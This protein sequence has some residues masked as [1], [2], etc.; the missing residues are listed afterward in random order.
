VLLVVLLR[1]K[2]HS[3][4]ARIG[5]D[6]KSLLDGSLMGTNQERE[7]GGRWW[8]LVEV[9]VEVWP[10][11]RAGVRAVIE[12]VKA[13]WLL[14]ASAV[15]VVWEL[16][17]GT[18][19]QPC[20]QAEGAAMVGPLDFVREQ[21]ERAPARQHLCWQLEGVERAAASWGARRASRMLRAARRARMS[22]NNMLS[23]PEINS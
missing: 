12:S 5:C 13:P 21:Q 2:G 1:E 16:E 19:W 22:S 4:A 17:P 18:Q 7:G 9:A 6:M 11:R 20:A 15:A 14:G 3:A 23:I 10:A 8:R